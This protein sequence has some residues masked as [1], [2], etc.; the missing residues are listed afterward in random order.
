[1][2]CTKCGFENPAGGKFCEE[3][4]Q[5]LAQ[6]CPQCGHESSPTAKFCGACGVPL[7]DLPATPVPAAEAMPAVLAPVLYTPPHLAERIL[8]E[9]AAM[10]ARGQAA[11]ERKTITA[12]FADMA[13]STA[14][15]QD[16]DPEEARGLIDP[17]IALM[18]EAV[19]HYEG[20]V[21]KSLGD[22]I[23][24]LFGAPI[25]H[26]DHPL[27]AL[28]AALRMQEAMRRHGDRV[29]L[30]QGV[31]LQIR[32]GIHTGEVVVRSI[33]KDD[34][35]A[36]YDPV[37][38]T[39]HI[40][41]RMEGVATPSSI[42]VSES[43]HK[44]TEGY[45]E[46]KGLGTTHVKGIREP[47][48]VYEVIGLGALRT[49]LQVA[50]H[51]GL[52]RFVG[53][54]AELERL[55]VALESAKAGQGQIVGVVGEAGV[56]K[57]RLYHEFKASS[58]RGCM[59]LETF[60]VSHG[61][62][63]PY[64]PLIDLMRNYF[65]ITAQDDERLYREKIT[66]R[67]LTLDRTLEE[68]LPYL[69]YLLGIREAGSTLPRMDATIRRQRTFE[70]IARLLV[71]ESRNQ[72]LMVLFEDLQWLDSE[73][74]AFLNILIEH[75]PGTRLLL[76]VNYR[77]EYAHDWDRKP[78]F[79]QL[80]L[81]PLEQ[82]EAQGLLTALLGDHLSLVPLKLLIQAKT[83]GNPFFM[84]EVVKTLAEESVLLG[85]PG[86]YRIEKA[87]LSLHIPPTV[88][89]VLAAR[90]DRLPVAQKDLLQT[91][92]IIGKEFPLSLIEHV[93]AQPEGQLR[94][95]L[96]DLQA[97]D[98]I[99]E[100]PAFPEVEYAFKH[101]LTQEV[102][103]NSLLTDRR[104]V[105]HE[106]TARAIEIL[107]PGRLKDYCSEL[108]HHYSKS[109]NTRKAIEYLELAGQQALQQSAHLEAV[110]HLS[111]ALEFLK[112][113]PD[114]PERARQ[115]LSLLLG[116]GIACI[117]ARG[118]GA[119]EVQTIYTRALALCEQGG[120]TPQLF[121]AQLG[122]WSFYLLRGQLET[123]QALAERL[124]GLAQDTQEPEQLA[125][126]HRVLGVTLF[127][128]GKLSLARTHMEEALTLHRPDRQSYSHLLR[129]ARN[130]AVHMRSTLSWILWY[131]GL[132]DQA[133]TR[134]EEAIEL[135]RKASDPFGLALSLIFAA[136]LHQRRCDVQRALE[137]ANAAIALSN[138]HGFQLYLAWGTI[139]RGWALAGHG[140]HEDGIAQMQQGFSA[141]DSTGAILG[142]PSLLGLLADAYGRAGQCD[143]ALRVTS[144][145]LT[146]ASG[147]G[148]RFDEP[149]LIRLK[150]ELLLQM[151][152]EDKEAEA[153][154]LKAI[155]LARDEGA[156]SIE[157]RC[158]L[159]LAR[160]WHG[161]G[162]NR[163][164]RQ[165]LAEIQGLFTEGFDTVDWR[166]A[167]EL[168][169]HLS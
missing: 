143:A 15:I 13:G 127:R 168:Q 129:Y 4:G 53:R 46:F 158:A 122:M 71:R 100:R 119:P 137:C 61:K 77:P 29:R 155:A 38:H 19:H 23:L 133:C 89:G 73:T 128:R 7:T 113:L 126:A 33:R 51:R 28:Y 17:V 112:S 68:H 103:A 20:Y 70:A 101:A 149:T 34:L 138:D 30:E 8:A 52:A 67:L 142:R 60:S 110:P 135:A 66:G 57:S 93:T 163:A 54:Q 95:L 69:L 59:V 136:E 91:L 21:A 161:Q 147:T 37:G 55:Q 79:T 104:S 153:C 50:A 130:P 85:Q 78:Y 92:A 35:R 121:S 24:A 39:I 58:Q 97:G 48:A 87:P 94:P 156:R 152:A 25:A 9:Q 148:E 141:L 96:S 111:A 45:F 107:F 146:L 134:S 105:L 120:D 162:R 76:L 151:T 164:A 5:R 160:L 49:R 56:G 22:G 157:L 75:V 1:M 2:R 132:P 6:I 167:K 84:E 88:Q 43:T 144:D 80:Q 65:Q 14:L 108:A 64:L 109:G 72:T 16:L 44:L 165:I 166:Q 62:A 36:D 81:E 82:G 18:M 117:T 139:L 124:H 154:F 102:V 26:E 40:A 114:T 32:V 86:S 10:E 63:F 123:A 11:G 118:H 150:G 169:E 140:S 159:S 47:L 12:L 74:E 41:S 3:C 145:A 125:E 98:F 115:E 27:R 116:L 99:Y 42:L 106:R 90:I 131:L 83:E 31:P